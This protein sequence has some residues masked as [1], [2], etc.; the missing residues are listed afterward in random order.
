MAENSKVIWSEGMFLRHQHFQQ[1]ERYVENYVND[2]FNMVLSEHW[3]VAS[4]SIDQQH[5]ALGR[6]AINQAKGI[7]PDGTPFDTD[8]GAVIKSV[9]ELPRDVHHQLVYLG[10]PLKGADLIDVDTNDSEV[11]ARHTAREEMTKDT[12]STQ[13]ESA[14]IMVGDLRL[15]LLL[16]NEDR[17]QFACIPITR[18]LEVKDDG[19]VVLDQDYIPPCLTCNASPKL[20]SY[21]R[22][23]KGTLQFR[24]E[25]LAGRV[26]NPSM[27][28]TK[29]MVDFFLLQLI[30]RYQSFL[31]HLAEK[32]ILPPQTFYEELLKF[33]GELSTY[34]TDAKRLHVYPEYK[35][36][37]LQETFTELM[38]LLRQSLV[39]VLDKNV[40]PLPLQ[41]SKQGIKVS[42]LSD[43]SLLDTCDFIVAVKAD[44]SAD[45]LR[46]RFSAQTKVAPIE[47]IRD[48]I[49]SQLPGF[50]LEGLPVAPPELPYHA[51]FIYFKVNKANALWNAMKDSAGFALY[52]SGDLPNAETEFWAIKH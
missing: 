35:H 20:S 41:D 33:T 12:A 50:N 14:S 24:G 25:E 52:L 29:V 30:N 34:T 31:G 37:N 7:F 46:N 43:K 2:I 28:G 21:L 18:V 40:V 47:K 32:R 19:S 26:A 45:T 8:D 36:D 1:Q 49:S 3:G 44:M 23:L 22:E 4:L 27:H 42:L 51:G 13:H 11:L 15:Q 5:L 17:S 39:H 16:E 10:L 38:T 48:L 9:L 6:F